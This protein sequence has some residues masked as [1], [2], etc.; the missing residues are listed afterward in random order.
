MSTEHKKSEVISLFENQLENVITNF[1]FNPDFINVLKS[2]N[3]EITVQF[4]VKLSSGKTEVF[5]GYRVQH[6]NILGP[7]KGGLRFAKDVYLDECKA[8]AFWMTIKCAIH[9]LPLGGGKG[10]IKYNPSDYSVDDNKKIV[11]AFGDKIYPFIGPNIDIP[12]PDVGSTSQHMDWLTT[13]YQ[14]MSGNKSEFSTF[15]GKSLDF[16]GSQ[17]RHYST[18]LGVVNTISYWFKHFFNTS[19]VDKTFIVQGFGN[20]GSW[21]YHFMIQEK[22]LCKAIADHT[23]YYLIDDSFHDFQS[24]FDYNTKNRSLSNI[25]S[26]IPQISKISAID[27]WKIKC[28]IIIPAA[29]ELQITEE[30]ASLIDCKLIAEGANG[31]TT[32]K[33]DIIL[34]K[35][36]IEVIPDVLCNSAGVIVSYFEW[37][38]NKTHDYWSLDTV[39]QKL[40][41]IITSSCDKLFSLK[42]S[43]KDKT[44][45]TLVYLMA[46]T[47]LQK[48]Y[49]NI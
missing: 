16:R 25:E 21:S 15:T 40:E 20:V 48:F 42:S 17:G 38:Q 10:G 49:N 32:D 6:N 35:K 24:I 34:A 4:P 36:G 39:K 46:L 5:T 3:S 18:G 44:N 23:G 7:Y 45:R 31:A 12:A 13:S 29:L 19:L 27:F 14:K 2:H 1:Q 47:T 8:L 28:D 33:A 41:N 37:I 43:H 22:A 11:Q 26:I 30:V 9:S